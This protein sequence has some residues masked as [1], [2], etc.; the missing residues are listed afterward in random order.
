[1]TPNMPDDDTFKFRDYAEGTDSKTPCP[2]CGTLIP[3]SATSCHDC[4]Q[5]FK[6][7]AEEF[8]PA[9]END[10][11]RMRR[12]VQRIAVVMLVILGLAVVTAAVISMMGE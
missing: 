12:N 2:K 11:S 3:R 8:N 5:H 1:M 9:F 10:G 6:G 4:G 7:W